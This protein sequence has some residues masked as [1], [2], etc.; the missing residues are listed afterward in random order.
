MPHARARVPFLAVA[1]MGAVLALGACGEDVRT[2]LDPSAPG[3]SP[4]AS[5]QDA[6]ISHAGVDPRPAVEQM[7]ELGA[8]VIRVDLRWDAVALRRPDDPRDPGDPA[9][10]WRQ[11]DRVVQAARASRVRVLFSVWGTPA[12]AADPDVPASRR[13]AA[14]ATRPADPEDFGAFG[15]AA[16][17]RYGPRGVRMWEAW[18]EPNIPLFLRPQY[19]LVGGSWQATSPQVYGRMLAAFYREVKAVQPEARVAGGVTAP[20]GDRCPF[21]CPNAADDRVSPIDFLDG[22]AQ[23][24]NQPPMDVYSHHPYPASPPRETNNPRASYVDL[25]NLGRLSRAIDRTYLRGRSLWL[26]EFGFPTV[27]VPDVGFVVSEDE[28]AAYLSDA[29]RRLHAMPRV[30]LFTWYFLRDSMEWSSGLLDREGRAKPALEAYALPV[31]PAT[32]GAVPSEHPVDVVGQVR[33]AAGRTTVTIERRDGDGWA[34]VGV[35]P[36]GPDGSFRARLS[37]SRTA[38]FRAS[39]EGTTRL[40]QEAALVSPPF[41]VTVG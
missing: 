13:F 22:L 5:L 17:G 27:K 33:P 12:W 24:G 16:A 25:Y 35:V 23:A 19:E 4:V 11:Y 26:S 28:Q 15:A 30:K 38:E 2:T 20:A 39:W 34:A 7:A 18:N 14:W 29:V 40:G 8:R 1:L 36:T 37:A 41:Q 21:S 6:A 10:D 31:A 3:R 32:T 9:Y